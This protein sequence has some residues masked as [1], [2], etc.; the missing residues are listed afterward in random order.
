VK[1]PK[2]FIALAVLFV[3]LGLNALGQAAA[4]VTGDSDDPVILTVLQTLV[5]ACGLAA[6]VGCWRAA[7]WTPLAALAY[8]VVTG[9]MVASLG[10]ML[11]LDPEAR[12]GVVMGGVSILVFSV[13]IAWWVRRVIHRSGN[14]RLIA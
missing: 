5:G 6:A 11:D 7:R 3:F 4:K 8:G 13:A 10:P 14:P 1:R 9:G 2:S 12:R